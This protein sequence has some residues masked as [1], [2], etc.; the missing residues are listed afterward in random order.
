MYRRKTTGL[1]TIESATL[2]LNVD[3]VNILAQYVSF[4]PEELSVSIAIFLNALISET[5]PL[6]SHEVDN[7]ITI[8]AHALNAW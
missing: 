6:G 3:L 5:S 8:N 7:F 2:M 4:V 1:G